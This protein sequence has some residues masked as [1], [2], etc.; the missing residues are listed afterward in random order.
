MVTLYASYGPSHIYFGFEIALMAM[1]YEFWKAPGKDIYSTWGT[2]LVVISLMFSPWLF[3][4]QSLQRSTLYSSW[5]EWTQWLYGRGNLSVGKGSWHNWAFE[6][7]QAKRNSALP[8]KAQLMLR[9]TLG[10]LVVLVACTEGLHLTLPAPQP[11][12]SYSFLW[13][14]YFVWHLFFLFRACFV[15]L[16]GSI[17]VALI[18]RTFEA[19]MLRAGRVRLLPLYTTAIMICAYGSMAALLLLFEYG[20]FDGFN[21]LGSRENVWK[22]MLAGCTFQ[23]GVVQVLGALSDAY[24]YEA[25]FSM[26]L[27][28]DLRSVNEE[29]LIRSLAKHLRGVH[30]ADITLVAKTSELQQDDACNLATNFT[31]KWLSPE[32]RFKENL[33]ARL[34]AGSVSVTEVTVTVATERVPVAKATIVRLQNHDA[35]TLSAVLADSLGDG[36]VIQKLSK[37]THSEAVLNMGCRSRVLMYAQFWQR[38]VDQTI[39]LVIF[40][41]LLMLS[42]LPILQLQ[43]KILFNREFADIINRKVHKQEVLDDL[44]TPG[45]FYE[46]AAD[47]S[48]LTEPRGGRLRKNLASGMRRGGIFKPPPGDDA[49]SKMDTVR[50]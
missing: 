11:T 36:T 50:V 18:I 27:V 30:A 10:K 39:T 19:A 9:N 17:Y 47:T 29:R 34:G 33:F 35:K 25:K 24:R 21:D 8:L 13:R 48:E 41:T 40:V 46:V 22:L 4:P 31:T 2:W 23:A 15:V 28:G 26:S 20:S 16:S 38:M 42:T 49:K 12:L 14:S 32:K 5:T 45:L 3:N 1:I 44:C 6:R 43:T 7:L 37:I